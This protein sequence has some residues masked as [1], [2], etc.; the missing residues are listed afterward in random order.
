MQDIRFDDIE[1]LRAKVSEAVRRL[2]TGGRG[3]AG[4]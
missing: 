2:G 3:H 4:R 1:A